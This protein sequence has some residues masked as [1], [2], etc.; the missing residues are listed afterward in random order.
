M[1]LKCYRNIFKNMSKIKKIKEVKRKAS[2][3]SV[4]IY[5]PT[6]D[7]NITLSLDKIYFSGHEAECET[8]GSHGSVEMSIHKCDCGKEH[9]ITLDS[10]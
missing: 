4:E 2:L 9:E 8:C 1:S 7:K 10:W 3:N 5:C 6:Y